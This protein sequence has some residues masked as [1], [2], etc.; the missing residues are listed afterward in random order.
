ML[1]T[2]DLLGPY[3]Y[4]TLRMMASRGGWGGGNHNNISSYLVGG[5]EG[6][7]NVLFQSGFTKRS[8][9]V[10]LPDFFFIRHKHTVSW[11]LRLWAQNKHYPV[12]WKKIPNSNSKQ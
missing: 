9:K 5:D 8:R 2:K 12:L 1:Y 6:E 11:E 10:L 7:K 3:L 4:C